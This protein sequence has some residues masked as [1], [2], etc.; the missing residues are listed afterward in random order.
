MKALKF[1]HCHCLRAV[2]ILLTAIIP[3]T[4]Q[5]QDRSGSTENKQLA[6]GRYYALVIGNN[7]YNKT[8]RRL[9]TAEDDAR[10]IENVLRNN[11]GF[12]T[13][14]LLNGTRQQ[15]ISALITYRRELDA[16][17]NLLIYYAGHGYL[18]R[19]ADKAYWLPV[20]ASFDDNSNWISSDDITTSTKTI[21]AKHVLIV[22][23]SCYSG[24]ITRGLEGSLATPLMR[25]K[26]LE[27][28]LAGKS[29]TLMSSGGNEPVA[30]GG[31]GG[32]HSVFAN[33]LLR[34]L[35]QSDKNQF[36]ADELFR[37][38][39]QESVAGRA[40]Q[41]P[42]YHVL[43]NSGHDSGDFVFLRKGS[44][45]I[46]PTADTTLNTAKVDAATEATSGFPKAPDPSAETNTPVDDFAS[47]PRGA[48]LSLTGTTWA[49]SRPETGE[50]TISFLKDGQ[51][52]YTINVL[53]NGVSSPKAIKGKWKQSGSD[54]QIIIG[55]Y[56]S[57]L[58]GIVEGNIIKGEGNNREG[59]KWN[60]TLFKKE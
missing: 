9:K 42:E 6:A 10:E 46:A 11:Y 43:R 40:S 47:K 14:L 28:M 56:Y 7:A 38:Y 58:Q 33:A 49:G 31:G 36:T 3:A 50:Y 2:L 37:A 12:Q 52:Q 32:K 18:D 20:D 29:R 59:T 57:V 25:Q 30:D 4:T 19:E 60:W 24:T 23:D 15:I 44:A 8:I 54:V 35:M 39:I 41:T 26:Y 22:S 48:G 45:T 5:M 51:L 21:P 1:I 27:K 53:E 17:A 34:G 55:D 13:K 16:D